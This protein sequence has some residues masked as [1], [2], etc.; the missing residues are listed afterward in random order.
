MD[1]DNIGTRLEMIQA[2]GDG[3]LPPLATFHDDDGF[4]KSGRFHQIANLFHRVT[5]R[6]DDDVIDHRRDIEFADCVNDDR[7]AVQGEKLLRAIRFHPA[8]EASG[9][10]DCADLHKED[11]CETSVCAC[12]SGARS[13]RGSG[14]LFR[15][16]RSS[17]G[18]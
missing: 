15:S 8:P 1:G 13:G 7:S 3:I 12:R 6:C 11:Q 4:F 18:G 14:W 2:R 16:G 10:D 5:R 17:R 9:S